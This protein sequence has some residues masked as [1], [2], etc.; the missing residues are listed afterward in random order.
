MSREHAIAQAAAHFDSGH[1][2]R[3]LQALVACP[4]E[5]QEPDRAGVLLDYLH[6]HLG[7]LLRELG[8][9]WQVLDNPVAGAPPL[10]VAKRQEPDAAFTVLAYGHGDVVRGHEGKWRGGRSPWTLD[11]E[12]DRWYGRGAADNKGQHAINL[13]ALGETIQARG[14]RLGYDVTWV[15]EMGEEIGSPGLDAFCARHADLLRADLFLASDGPRLGATKPTVFLGARGGCNFDLSLDLREGAH[16][17]GNWGGLLRNPAWRLA[18]ALASLVDANGRILVPGLLPNELPA[19]VRAAL[20]DV[21]VASDAGDPE[22]DPGWG[23]PGLSPAEQVFGWNTL[24]ILAFTA[25]TPESP[26]NAIPGQ[27]RA[28]CQIRYVVGSDPDHFLAHI[29]AHLDAHGYTDVALAQSGEMFRA[30]RLDPD[31]PWV[32]LVLQ[33]LARTTGR[34]ATL[35][36]NLGGSL[37]NDVFAETLGL[38]TVWVPH[39]YPACSQHAPNEHLLGSVAREAL[40]IMAGL[41]WDLGE[42]GGAIARALRDR[43]RAIAPGP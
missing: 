41:Y 2:Q 15:F 5:C 25:G 17:S 27:A 38:P 33:S 16:H 29:R 31:N 3:R 9:D 32:E 11:V 28:H 14:G 42:R 8:F 12:G 13:A 21:R 19:N 36:P 7:P 43:P 30:T 34:P 22:I 10:M 20:R 23:E 26:V 6:A 40:Q 18:H 37:P 1:F 24:E 35:L 4:T 39:S